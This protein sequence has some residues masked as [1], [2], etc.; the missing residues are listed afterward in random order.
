MICIFNMSEFRIVVSLNNYR[1]ENKV[2]N[3]VF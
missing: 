1:L 3:G 2:K